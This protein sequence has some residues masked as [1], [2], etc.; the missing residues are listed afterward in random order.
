MRYDLIPVSGK[1]YKANLHTH[2]TVSDGALSPEKLKE[3]YKKQGYSILALTDHEMLVDHSCLN[4]SD[5]LTVTSY[6]YAFIEDRENYPC[7]RTVEFNLFARNPHNTTQVCFEPTSAAQPHY[8]EAW[9][10]P[11]IKYGG[12]PFCKEFT[13]EC[14][15]R[16]IDEA[17]ANGFLVSLNH[18]NYSMITPE[19]FGKFNGLFAMEIY[20][21]ISLCGGVN[22]YNP[23]MYETVLRQGKNLFCIAADDAHSDLDADNPYC[24][25]FGG[26]VMMKLP[27]LNY[28]SVIA[29]LENGDFYAS[30]GPEIHSLYVEDKKVHLT[31]SPAKYVTMNGF[32]R[33]NSR[34]VAP[35]GE[36]VTEA[37][38]DI[39]ED[40]PY[41][42]FTVFDEFGH[43]ADTHAYPT[44]YE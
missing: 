36:T 10:V 44:K 22:D 33:H 5:F 7:S 11:S 26:F 31:F 18:P 41:M 21:H 32:Y 40:D 37:T 13:V 12:E 3:L 16:V 14:M 15:Q 19:L 29:A 9:R 27:S 2:S 39:C 38:F 28:D 6:E 25:K 42:R 17:N 30:T 23:Q 34:I 4:D 20:N 35:I 1:F 24:D 43:H 8:K